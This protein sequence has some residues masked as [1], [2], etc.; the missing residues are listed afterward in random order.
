ML[1]LWK[2]VVQRLMSETKQRLS[3]HN[4]LDGYVAI[5][6]LSDDRAS[7][8]YV[9]LKSKYAKKLG[10]YADIKFGKDRD[11]DEIQEELM[12]CNN[13]PKCL[14]ILVQ[15]PLAD[16]LQTEQF[17]L[18]EMISPDKDIDGLTSRL[19]G[20]AWFGK[21]FLGAT[22]QASM[23]ILDHYDMWDVYGK[24][25]M[26]ISQ[27][28]LIGKPL[29]LELMKRGATVISTNS[30][31]PAEMFQEWFD[32]SEYIFAATGVKHLIH[33]D[34]VNKN[35][36]IKNKVLM[37]IGRWSDEDGP[38]GDVDR[39]WFADKVRGVTPVPGGVGPVTVATLF[40]NILKL[41]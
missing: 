38:H 39:E 12:Q 25:C 41:R 35:S 10:I 13:D 7:E 19:F 1:L 37:D 34:L 26:V 15:L 4:K 2:P 17:I 8:M 23:H 21:E 22:P 33:R 36:N 9:S 40:H 11:V 30:K 29:A 6:L 3:D 14:G 27:S 32:R 18:L 28:N 20:E 5:F 24:V 31:T 16:R